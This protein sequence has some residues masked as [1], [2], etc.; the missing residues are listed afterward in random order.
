MR[1]AVRDTGFKAQ[2][3]G[4]V[5]AWRSV[6]QLVT[7]GVSELGFGF[8][9][10]GA[11]GKVELGPINAIVDAFEGVVK[12]FP[13]YVKISISEREQRHRHDVPAF[14]YMN[15]Q[16]NTACCTGIGN[17]DF[18]SGENAEVQHTEPVSLQGRV[19]VVLA[20]GVAHAEFQL[21]EYG[22]C[23]GFLLPVMWMLSI[24]SQPDWVESA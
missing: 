17:Q 13:P 16:R 7:V 23:P 20:Q 8:Q 21:P 9:G 6:L 11:S 19:E 22:R 3:A 15:N 5:E 18:R 10:I 2:G 4:A 12:F 14:C 1:P 24:F